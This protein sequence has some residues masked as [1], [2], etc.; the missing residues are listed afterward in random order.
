MSTLPNT[1][2]NFI[3][4]SR[5][6]PVKSVSV[7]VLP[8]VFTM[9]PEALL[10]VVATYFK[11]CATLL[12]A[13]FAVAAVGNGV[14]VISGAAV[15]GAMGASVPCVFIGIAVVAGASVAALVAAAAAPVVPTAMPVAAA[16]P[17]V[18]AAMPVAAAAVVPAG[19]A[20]VAAAMASVVAPAMAVAAAAAVVPA[21]MPVAPISVVTPPGM[22]VVPAAIVSVAG[23]A[24][25]PAWLCCASYHGL[26]S[27]GSSMLSLFTSIVSKILS[28]GAIRLDCAFC[29]SAAAVSA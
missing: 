7:I 15:V 21:A 18:A 26:N 11:T 2:K 29:S 20:V 23:A 4:P 12:L 19:I 5:R 24:V 6:S 17:V 25:D 13:G 27:L 1:L 8:F 9:C 16:A 22:F 28:N 3:W 10:G 14:A